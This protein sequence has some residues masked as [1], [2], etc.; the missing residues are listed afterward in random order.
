[1]GSNFSSYY[2]ADAYM[3][4]NFLLIAVEVSLQN[5]M[6]HGVQLPAFKSSLGT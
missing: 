6:R 3:S 2:M 1:M 5:N 4:E